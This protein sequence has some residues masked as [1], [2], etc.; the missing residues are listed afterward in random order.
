MRSGGRPGLELARMLVDTLGPIAVLL[1]AMTA[2]CLMAVL[3]RI[4]QA[5]RQHDALL[6][7]LGVN[8]TKAAVGALTTTCPNCQAEFTR[9]PA[10]CPQCGARQK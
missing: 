4:A 3:A 9:G 8:P 10:A 7:A 1:L 5:A 2:A 6:R